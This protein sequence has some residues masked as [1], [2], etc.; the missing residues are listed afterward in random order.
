[1]SERYQNPGCFLTF[2]GPLVVVLSVLG[3]WA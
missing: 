1:M 3:I 2:V